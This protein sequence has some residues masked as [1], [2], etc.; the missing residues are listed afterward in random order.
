MK[1]KYLDIIFTNH[2]ITRLY[3]RGIS[4]S[5]AWETFKHPDRVIEGKIAGSKKFYK[6]LKGKKIEVVAQPNK[7]GEWVVFSCWTKENGYKEKSYKGSA[8][9]HYNFLERFISNLLGKL[10]FKR[11]N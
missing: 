10:L 2:A 3:N 11:K 6:D 7:K 8:N 1:K 4:Q 9:E 5:D